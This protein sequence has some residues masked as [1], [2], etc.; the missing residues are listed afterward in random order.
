MS[1]QWFKSP[2]LVGGW[3]TAQENQSNNMLELA[4]AGDFSPDDFS[5]DFN[6]GIIS[7]DGWITHPIDYQV[8][9]Q[10]Q[11]FYPVGLMPIGLDLTPRALL[12][13]RPYG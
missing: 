11:Q 7:L 9:D 6:I 10:Q 2:D 12:G 8:N 4:V 5:A 1:Q 3:K 13:V